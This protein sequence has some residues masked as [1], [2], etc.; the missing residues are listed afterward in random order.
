MLGDAIT[1]FDEINGLGG[2]NRENVHFPPI[3][4]Q[5]CLHF[6]MYMESEIERVKG[7]SKSLSSYSLWD[8]HVQRATGGAITFTT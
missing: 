5:G 3:D 6:G 8:K 2:G 1:V 7:R 4:V